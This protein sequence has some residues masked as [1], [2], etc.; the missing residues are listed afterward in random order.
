[1]RAN[2]VP[3]GVPIPAVCPLSRKPEC[4]GRECHR[5][6]PGNLCT[7][8]DAG[9][10]NACRNKRRWLALWDEVVDIFTWTSDGPSENDSETADFDR[11]GSLYDM[12][13]Q[14]EA[15]SSSSYRLVVEIGLG[16]DDAQLLAGGRESANSPSLEVSVHRG[17]SLVAELGKRLRP[18][19]GS[20][21]R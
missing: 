5:W 21:K 11:A 1:M 6:R 9:N 15:C 17:F 8:P 20:D 14:K 2:K 13:T 10:L 12:P 19:R 4:W 16:S 7:H 18:Q 3:V